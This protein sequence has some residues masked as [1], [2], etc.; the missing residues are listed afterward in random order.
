MTNILRPLIIEFA[1]MSSLVHPHVTKTCLSAT[2][3]ML[4]FYCGEAGNEATKK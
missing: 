3:V 2:D 4:P 1:W